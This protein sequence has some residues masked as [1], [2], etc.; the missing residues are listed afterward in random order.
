MTIKQS[1]VSIAATLVLILPMLTQAGEANVNLPKMPLLQAPLSATQ[2]PVKMYKSPNCDCCTGWA[3]HLKKNGY[4]VTTYTREDMD[5]VKSKYGVS[6]KLRSC[7]TAL[8]GGYVIEG[9]VPAEDVTRLLNEHPDIVGLTAP[10]MPMQSPGMQA[11]GQKPHGYD[12]LAFTQDGKITVF[13]SY[14]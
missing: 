7:H 2:H 10:G 13:H 12:V 14:P 8:V 11:E 9:H 6:A 4:Q 1:F 3:E 5:I